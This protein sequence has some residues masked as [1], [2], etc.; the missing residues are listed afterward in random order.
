MSVPLAPTA[1]DLLCSV[2]DFGCVGGDDD[3]GG[4]GDRQKGVVEVVEVTVVGKD[5]G[6]GEAD[7][8]SSHLWC[9][10][11]EAKGRW[12]LTGYANGWRRLRCVNGRF[13]YPHGNAAMEGG[14]EDG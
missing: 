1:S 9:V 3:G 13:E 14:C 8:P 2:T 10:F 7:G 11:V 6:E 5:G 4:G 12:G